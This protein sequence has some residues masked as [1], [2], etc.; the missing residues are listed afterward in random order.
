VQRQYG[1]NLSDLL[2][3]RSRGSEDYQTNLQTI[4]RNFSQLGNQQAQQGRAGRARGRLRH[5]GG[6]QARRQ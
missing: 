5:A 4:A 3:A 2:K 6:A 1:E